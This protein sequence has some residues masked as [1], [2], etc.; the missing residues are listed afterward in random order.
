MCYINEYIYKA[1]VVDLITV[2]VI[3]KCALYYKLSFIIII[4]NTAKSTNC[5]KSSF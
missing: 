4:Y 5:I 3:V 2:K 1:M